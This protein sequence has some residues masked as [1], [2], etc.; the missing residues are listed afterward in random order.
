[1]KERDLQIL[2]LL[3]PDDR[4][5]IEEVVD[6]IIAESLP[7]PEPIYLRGAAESFDERAASLPDTEKIVALQIAAALR[8]RAAPHPRAH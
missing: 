1:M 7:A 2:A 5:K 4:S 6:E 8:M 3:G